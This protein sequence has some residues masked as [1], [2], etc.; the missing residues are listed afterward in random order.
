[1]LTK[2]PKHHANHRR[3]P[4]VAR[5]ELEGLRILDK[6][7]T[8][9]WDVMSRQHEAAKKALDN[10]VDPLDKLGGL[11]E[12]M[13]TMDQRQPP[14]SSAA[15]VQTFMVLADHIREIRGHHD[16]FCEEYDKYLEAVKTVT[17]EK[18]VA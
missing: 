14:P 12:V 10:I 5:K 7:M 4:T 3:P 15:L 9:L 18:A 17:E 6:E 16:T 13:R 8:T 2:Q 11:I 1:M